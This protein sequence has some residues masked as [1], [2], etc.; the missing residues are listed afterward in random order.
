MSQHRAEALVLGDGRV[1]HA[2]IHVEDFVGQGLSFAQSLARNFEAVM[3]FKHLNRQGW[4]E[5]SVA[6]FD[7]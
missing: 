3:L 7:R 1:G 6:L 2:L 4:A 5:V